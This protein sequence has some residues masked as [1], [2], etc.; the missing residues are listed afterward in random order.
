M[1][2][3]Y[4]LAQYAGRVIK[5]LGAEGL[6]EDEQAKILD[7][8]LERLNKVVA[9]TTL[10]LLDQGQKARFAAAL[11]NPQARDGAMAELAAEVPHLA[12]IL[13]EALSDEYEVMKQAMRG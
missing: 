3:I 5:D 12:E 10:K 8:V 13:E 11:E 7:L 2:T 1:D 9:V 6:S 4:N